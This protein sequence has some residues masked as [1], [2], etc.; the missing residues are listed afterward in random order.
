MG[1]QG[2]DRTQILAQYF[3]G[4]VAAD[5]A[6]G[7]TWQMLGGLGFTLETQDPADGAYL[8][9]IGGALGEAEARSGLRASRAITVRAFRST[10]AFRDATLAPGWVAAFTEGDWI[11]TQPLTTLA[12]RRML[13]SLLRHEF[14]HALVEAQSAPWTPLWLREGLVEVWSGEA[15]GAGLPPNLKTDEIDRALAHA[16]TE[17]QSHDAHWAAGWYASKLFDRYGRGT[18]LGWLRIGVP[19]NVL[20]GLH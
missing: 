16:R 4:A 2:R 9:Q 5:E 6:N 10:P 14:L 20:A 12:R 15:N 18:V 1:V 7:L 19:A 17:V 11:A 13:G 8:G 3:P